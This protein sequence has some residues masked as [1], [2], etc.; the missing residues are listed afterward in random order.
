MILPREDPMNLSLR[1]AQ[2]TLVSLIV[3]IYALT[4]ALTGDGARAETRITAPCQQ[5]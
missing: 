1:L 3:G 5:P 4:H 2:L